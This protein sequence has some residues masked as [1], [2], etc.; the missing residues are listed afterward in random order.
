M[1]KE[2]FKT[3]LEEVLTVAPGT[4]SENDTRKTLENWS[5]LVD[6]EILT[7]VA[8]EFGIDAELLEYESIGELLNLLED[9]RV[10]SAA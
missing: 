2:A 7:V 9:Q 3:L 4:L 1:T 6:V 8:S 5:S 10:F